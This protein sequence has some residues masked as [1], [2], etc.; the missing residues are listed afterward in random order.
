MSHARRQRPNGSA[1]RSRSAAARATPGAGRHRSIVELYRGWLISGIVAV[2]AVAVI[3]ILVL[4]FGPSNSGKDAAAGAQPADPGLVATITG[5]PTATFDSI[6]VGSAA[7]PPRA[8]PST[9]SALQ[10]DGKP[11]LLYIGAE[12]CPYCAAQRWALMVALSRFGSFSNLHTTRSAANDAYP[13]TPTFTFYN[14][15]YAS[16]YLAFV[17][18]EQT[19]N[20]PKGN[21]GYTSLQ[22]LD[23]DQQGLLG[24]YDRP[25]YTDSVGGIPFTDYGGKYVHVGA[26]YDPGLLAGKDWNQVAI[27]IADPSSAQAKAILGSAN[28]VSATICRM[29]GGQPGNVCQSAGVQAAAAKSGG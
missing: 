1:A 11:E 19:T 26:M 8:L 24:Q 15:Q 12:Y 13:D 5:V 28:L 9:A 20:Q 3:A 6:G 17:A 10:K 7:N 22:S 4:K 29:T 2:V 16:Q 25:P 23:A 18:V 14:A 27:L 21:G